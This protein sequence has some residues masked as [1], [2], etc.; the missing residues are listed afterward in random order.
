MLRVEARRR[1][2]DK[3]HHPLYITSGHS[4]AHRRQ[5]KDNTHRVNQ[6]LGAAAGSDKS[7]ETSLVRLKRVR[8]DSLPPATVPD[9]Q[10]ARSI[11]TDEHSHQHL[12]TDANTKISDKPNSDKPTT[13]SHTTSGSRGLKTSKKRLGGRQ[14]ENSPRRLPLSTDRAAHDA[15]IKKIK[16]YRKRNSVNRKDGRRGQQSKNE[17]SDETSTV[18]DRQRQKPTRNSRPAIE[19][20]S[21]ADRHR[22]STDNRWRPSTQPRTTSRQHQTDVIIVGNSTPKTAGKNPLQSAMSRD[23]VQR[24]RDV[25]RNPAS[26]RSHEGSNDKTS[27][28][29]RKKRRLAPEIEPAKYTMTP[30]R[31]GHVDGHARL[32][33]RHNNV[34]VGTTSTR[35]YQDAHHHPQHQQQRRA[36]RD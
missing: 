10:R 31:A 13:L 32:R 27:S 36:R 26:G 4:S 23:R 35:V 1:V 21:L 34:V 5:N 20:L 7:A 16:A 3:P 15:L 12:S 25:E 17:K 11:Q 2:E 22:P 14:H 8:R 9:V 6:P 30:T 24:V 28:R 18:R 29:L 33:P 19:R